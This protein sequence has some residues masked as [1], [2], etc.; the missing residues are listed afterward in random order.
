MPH[1]FRVTAA[2]LPRRRFLYL[3]AGAAAIPATLRSARAQ[4]YPS[5]PV[6]L[7]VGFPPGSATD[8]FGRLAGQWL[9]ERLDQPFVI[10]NRAG[11]GS[12]IAAEAVV[13]ISIF[14]S[15]SNLCVLNQ[16]VLTRLSLQKSSLA[17]SRNRMV[18][19][20]SFSTL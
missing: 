20:L 16:N 17:I 15:S 13:P 2:N 8:F 7:I 9:S 6:R 11:A 14:S 19:F 10:E 3:A 4:T 1:P 18:K 5:R 12:N